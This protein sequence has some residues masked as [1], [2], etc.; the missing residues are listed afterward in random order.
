MK[1]FNLLWFFWL[2]LVVIWNFI[3]PDVKPILDVLIAVV[4]SILLYQF[5][6]RKK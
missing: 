4:L 6:N 1:Q 5:N 2:V 3:F